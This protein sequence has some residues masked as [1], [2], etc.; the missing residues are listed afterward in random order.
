MR[1]T[2]SVQRG[3]SRHFF[4]S[5]A[6]LFPLLAFHSILRPGRHSHKKSKDFVVHFFTALIKHELC[7]KYEKCIVNVSYFVVCFTKT[8]AKYLRNAKY[9]SVQPASKDKIDRNFQGHSAI[10]LPVQIKRKCTMKRPICA[11]RCRL[12]LFC[13]GG[14]CN[15]P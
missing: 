3:I 12:S 1:K 4:S 6:P 9:E 8:F 5:Y 2:K 10:S 15:F 7:M 13:N 14:G 11:S